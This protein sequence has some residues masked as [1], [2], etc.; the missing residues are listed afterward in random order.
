MHDGK[1]QIIANLTLF[2]I[3]KESNQ[4]QRALLLESRTD[5]VEGVEVRHR[6]LLPTGSALELP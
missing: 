3:W 1:Q 2:V 4:K 6:A 5:S